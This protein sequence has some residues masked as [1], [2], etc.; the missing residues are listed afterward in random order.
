MEHQNEL[1]GGMKGGIDY[2]L[3]PQDS[4]LYCLNGYHV[5]KDEH[6]V[7]MTNIKGTVPVAQFA[8]GRIS[9]RYMSIC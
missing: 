8:V 9:Y 5:S 2:T 1:T 7:I 3:M 6:G 4:Y